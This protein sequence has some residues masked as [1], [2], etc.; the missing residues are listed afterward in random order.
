MKQCLESTDSQ[1]FQSWQRKDNQNRHNEFDTI[2]II[3]NYK[4]TEDEQCIKWK[5]VLFWCERN[6]LLM[7]RK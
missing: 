1:S 4:Y 2:I 6:G 5:I 3:Y 7:F